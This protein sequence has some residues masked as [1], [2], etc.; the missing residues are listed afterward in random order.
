[1]M[2]KLRNDCHGRRILKIVMLPLKIIR[3][4][5]NRYCFR[6]PYRTQDTFL[7]HTLQNIRYNKILKML[8]DSNYRIKCICDNLIN[9]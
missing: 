3:E 5:Y 7:K 8:Q 6:L 1:M 4:N 2:Y 9:L